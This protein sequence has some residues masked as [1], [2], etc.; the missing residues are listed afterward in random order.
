MLIC[1]GSAADETFTYLT[2]NLLR[3]G[4]EAHVIDI[5]SFAYSGSLQ[6]DL[7]K[8]SQSFLQLGQRNHFLGDYSGAWVRLINIS[9][10]APNER[11]SNRSA[12]QHQALSIFFD[13][14]PMAVV[15]PPSRSGGNYAKVA[16][17]RILS[18][19][20]DFEMPRSCLTDDQ[21]VAKE[22]IIS[23]PKGAVFKGAS[24]QKTWAC[25]YRKSDHAERLRLLANCPTLFQEYIPGPN[26]RVHVVG[27]QAFAEKITSPE[28]D[29]RTAKGNRYEAISL[30]LEIR[31]PCILM[32]KNLGI[33]FMGIDFIIEEGS[34]NWIFL[35]ANSAPCFQGYDIR[36]NGKICRALGDYLA[37]QEVSVDAAL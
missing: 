16:H 9:E 30:P 33:P 2:G 7:K 17:G 26:V 3:M 21:L 23:C 11:L 27:N 14:A 15:N 10:Q 8:P 18:S 29:Y 12:D 31:D 34:G 32:C 6:V 28:L 20:A 22:F 25:L 24:G 37:F 1:L 4:L 19:L 36:A 35:E 13:I 5:A